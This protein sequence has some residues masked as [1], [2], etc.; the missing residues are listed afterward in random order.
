MMAYLYWR[1]Y[2]LR[3]IRV[4]PFYIIGPRKTSDS[5]SDF[6]RGIAMV[7]KGQAETL[8]T[9]NLDVI[10]DIVDIRDCVRAMWLLTERGIPGEVYNICSGRGYKM[11][12]VLDKL[13]SLS[14]S[15]VKVCQSLEK[16]RPSDDS[17]LIGDNAKLCKLGW[18]PQI[19]IKKAL[20]NMLEYWRKN[21][22]NCSKER[23]K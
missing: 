10:R 1:T 5:C 9:G 23:C 3:I 20:S 4:R 2:N 11:R 15:K 21:L 17:I 12:D 18:K 6:A 14:P 8:S 16:I 19:P 7:E 13:L 22:D